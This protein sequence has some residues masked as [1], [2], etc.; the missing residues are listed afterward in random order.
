M[1]RW[2]ELVHFNPCPND[3]YNA[4]STPIYQSATFA[5]KSALGGNE[6]DYTRSGNPTRHILEAQLAKLEAGTAAFAFAT[7]M[8]ATTTLTGMLKAGAHIIVADD[9]YGG[10]YRL[11]TK[12]LQTHNNIQISFID[13]TNLSQLRQAIQPNTKLILLETPSNPLQKITDIAA[14]AEIAKQYNIIFA[15]DN[16]FMSPWLQR[17]LLLGADV[18]IHSATKYLSGHSDVCGGFLVVNNASLAEEIA[19]IQN[20]EGS[21]LAPFDCWLILRSLKTLALRIERSQR[22]ALKIAQHLLSQPTI[23]K[24]YYP[25]LDSHIG[26]NIHKKQASGGGAV[27]CFQTKNKDFAEFIVNNTKLFTISVSFGSV[28]SSISLPIYMSHASLT[29][30]IIPSNLV[31]LSIGIEDYEDLIDDLVETINTKII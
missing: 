31:R 7:G 30:N 8:A 23:T 18:V 22:N 27:I 15:V 17:P 20:A 12:R 16:S 19:F 2:T 28:N 5:Q 4:N 9:L 6:Y 14:V 29:K 21:A 11:L 1:N 26:A 24:V 25:L 13:T 3:P 10:T